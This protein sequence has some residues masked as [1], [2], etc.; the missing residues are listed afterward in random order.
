M[1]AS[2][3]AWLERW[4]ETELRFWEIIEARDWREDL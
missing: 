2:R 4:L 3:G 1:E